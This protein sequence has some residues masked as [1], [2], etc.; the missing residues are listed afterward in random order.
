MVDRDDLIR[1]LYDEFMRQFHHADIKELKQIS[2]GYGP[3]DIHVLGDVR[4]NEFADNIYPK[5]VK[6]FAA[7]QK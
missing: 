6:L 2:L 4:L 7:D 5:L 3:R 1:I